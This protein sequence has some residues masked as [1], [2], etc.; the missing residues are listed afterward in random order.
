MK[1]HLSRGRQPAEATMLAL[2]TEP[3]PGASAPGGTRLTL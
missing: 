1:P 3:E 2:R